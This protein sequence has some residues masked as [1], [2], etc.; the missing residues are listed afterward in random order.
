MAASA[1]GQLVPDLY[2]Q[3]SLSCSPRLLRP[4]LAFEVQGNEKC[5]HDNLY[6]AHVL[7]L[8]HDQ[9]HGHVWPFA[10]HH[11]ARCKPHRA[12]RGFVRIIRKLFKEPKRTVRVIFPSASLLCTLFTH[13]FP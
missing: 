8:R 5:L 3:R 4:P 10:T 6:H 11:I 2:V 13:A 9:L 7:L 1:V 12:D